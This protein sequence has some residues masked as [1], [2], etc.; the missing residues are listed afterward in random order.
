MTPEARHEKDRHNCQEYLKT[1]GK[2]AVCALCYGQKPIS[3]HLQSESTLKVLSAVARDEGTN[4]VTVATLGDEVVSSGTSTSCRAAKSE[5]WCADCDNRIGSRIEEKYQRRMEKL[6]VVDEVTFLFASRQFFVR[7]FLTNQAADPAH[8]ANLLPFELLDFLRVVL[9]SVVYPG[10]EFA[11]PQTKEFCLKLL[12]LPC[13]LPWRVLP[14]ALHPSTN[15]YL[16][17]R[18]KQFIFCGD[19]GV[20]FGQ[21]DRSIFAFTPYHFAML[22]FSDVKADDTWV[23]KPPPPAVR[24][25]DSSFCVYCMKRFKE[26]KELNRHKKSCIDRANKGP[27]QESVHDLLVKQCASLEIPP[28]VYDDSLLLRVEWQTGVA[29]F[30]K[31]DTYADVLQLLKIMFDDQTQF[32]FKAFLNNHFPQAEKAVKKMKTKS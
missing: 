15:M 22:V 18:I 26:R 6:M 12:A 16:A 4:F 17:R 7:L 20:F 9:L 25:D 29:N 10:E 2:L 31:E 5:L 3:S 19:S 1:K 11:F 30:S 8:P 27:V 28:Q 21:N 23:F 13:A 24:K 14:T 32:G